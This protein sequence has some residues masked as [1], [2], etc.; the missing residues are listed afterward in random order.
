VG[1]ELQQI[2][3]V[4]FSIQIERQQ[5]G[6]QVSNSPRQ[7][8]LFDELLQ[9][10]RLQPEKLCRMAGIESKQGLAQPLSFRCICGGDEPQFNKKIRGVSVLKPRTN[11][12]VS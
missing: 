10:L 7:Q 3:A 4:V 8:R 5:E 2:R 6:V 1:A 11:A 9:P 12:R